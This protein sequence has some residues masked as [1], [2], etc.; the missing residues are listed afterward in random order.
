MG[1]THA[2]SMAARAGGG[3][4][5]QINGALRIP[6]L[7]IAAARE[8]LPA[9]GFPIATEDVGGWDSRKIIFKL[10]TGEVSV[11]RGSEL[12]RSA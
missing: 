6:E 10:G 5:P 12:A 11:R 7:N 2:A 3:A 4:S 8:L 9:S 1:S